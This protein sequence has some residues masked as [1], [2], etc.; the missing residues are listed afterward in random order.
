[1]KLSD[2]IIKLNEV[3]STNE[4]MKNLYSKQIIEHG[5]VV[6]AAE[7]NKGRGQHG[8]LWDSNV[9]ENLLFTFFSK[10]TRLTKEQFSFAV[11][12]AVL[13]LVKRYVSQEKVTVKWPNDVL[14]NGEKIAGILIENRLKGD[15]IEASF[16]GVGLNVNQLSFSRFT[17]MAC[18]LKSLTGKTI[19]VD[20]LTKELWQLVALNLERNEEEVKALYD[21]SLYVLG[22]KVPF[23]VKGKQTQLTVVKVNLKG[24][25]VVR[26]DEGK[27]LFFYMGELKYLI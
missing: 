23:L 5:L 13:E 18:S 4:Y 7:Q 21:A 19:D 26:N 25:L 12:V 22:E 8:K 15:S 6:V 9:G 10:K 3:D 27:L 20:V 16:V 17:R 14:V 24:E 2:E 1:M 11:S